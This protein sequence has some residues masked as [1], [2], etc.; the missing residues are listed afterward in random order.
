MI[1]V[2]KILTYTTTIVSS[3]TDSNSSLIYILFIAQSWMYRY[4]VTFASWKKLQQLP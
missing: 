2:T 1:K 4:N 3:P